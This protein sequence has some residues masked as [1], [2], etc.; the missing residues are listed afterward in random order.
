MRQLTFVKALM[1]FFGRKE[2]QTSG[3]LLAEIKAL[4]P[5]DREWFAKEFLKVGIEIIPVA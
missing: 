4:T 5:E 3:D 2:G 1:E